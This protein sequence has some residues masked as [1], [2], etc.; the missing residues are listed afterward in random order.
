MK[1]DLD[2]LMAERGQD[3]IVIPVTE[4]YS[5][6][7]DYLANGAHI[8]R[9]FVI[10]KRGDTPFLI[11]DA[12][13]AGEAKLSGLDVYTLTGDLGYADLLE[14]AEGNF[15]KVTVALWGRALEKAGVTEG[16]IGIYG[17]GDFNYIIELLPLLRAAY[18]QYEFGGE[19]GETVFHQATLTK[20]DDE[21][22]R[23]KSVAKRTGIVWQNVW[24]FIS[25]HRAEGEMVVD[26]DGTPLTIGEV[27]RVLRRELTEQGLEDTGTIFAQGHDAGFPHSRGQDDMALKLGQTIVFDLFP[28]ELGGGYHHD[29]TRTWCIGHATEE[30]Q[31]A[32]DTV[33]EAFDVAVEVFAPGKP[34]HLMQEA[35]QTYFESKDHPTAH[36]HPGTDVGYTHGLGHGVGL[37]IHES[38]RINHY[39]KKHSFEVGNVFTIEPGVYYPDQEL[40]VRIEDTFYVNKKGELVSL[41]DFRKDLVL[42]LKGKTQ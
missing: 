35:V 9:G 16:K 30:A 23:I 42:P 15:T 2:R 7:V 40:G 24:D 20:D 26:A 21:I 12:M 22:E 19:M 37:E 33:M 4:M 31:A 39:S 29:S 5:M 34:T 10:K 36:S 18:P 41:T 11:V 6:M 27:R 25:N 17:T 3:A 38:L 28:R 8:G 32:Y 13:E 1:A 14:A